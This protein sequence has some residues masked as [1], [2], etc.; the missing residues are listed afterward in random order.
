MHGFSSLVVEK[1][2]AKY[3]LS[4]DNAISF[5]YCNYKEP[6]KSTEYMKAAIKQLARRMSEFP[7]DIE[8]LYDNASNPGNTELQNSFIQISSSFKQVF[9]VLDALDECTE[10]Q[11]SDLF[12]IFRSIVAP[13]SGSVRVNIKL[14]ITSREEPDIKRGFENFPL[15]KIETK[16]VDADI[17]SYV[18]SQLKNLRSEDASLK[19]E[20]VN[21]LVARAGEMYV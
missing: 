18:T 2:S 16:K 3:R 21:Q 12:D 8:Q 1:L 19:D 11:K 17:K 15:I 10:D 14:F 6:Q 4:S 20:V 9:L 5:I 13:S 7:A